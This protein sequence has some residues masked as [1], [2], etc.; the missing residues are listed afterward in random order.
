MNISFLQ[1]SDITA[2]KAVIQSR[3]TI[4]YGVSINK[5]FY[6]LSSNSIDSFYKT[7]LLLKVGK[8]ATDKSVTSFAE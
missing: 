7:K 2:A 8:V 3:F 4:R 1:T 5:K 6:W